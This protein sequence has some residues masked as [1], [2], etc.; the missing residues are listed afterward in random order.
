MSDDELRAALTKRIAD[1]GDPGAIVVGYAA[2]V[3][4]V[5]AGEDGP[6]LKTLADKDSPAWAQLGRT[7]ALKS[8]FERS[9]DDGWNED[10]DD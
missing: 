4:V 7:Y 3:E 2:V 10:D 1:L 6:W 9:L 8:L 5:T